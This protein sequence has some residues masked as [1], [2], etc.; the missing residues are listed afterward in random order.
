MK[1]NNKYS[2]SRLLLLIAGIIPSFLAF[3]F[4][5]KKNWIVFS[6]EFNKY[7]N[8]SSKYLFLYFLN[9]KSDS[10][11]LFFVINDRKRRNELI[12]EYGDYFIGTNTLSGILKVILSYTWITSSIETPIG[13]FFLRCRRIVIH[14][15][16]G[17]PVKSVGLSENYSS[18]KKFIYYN[19]V[20][21]NFTHFFSTSELFDE[22]WSKCIGIGKDRVIRA[23]LARNDVVVSELSC[24]HPV[25]KKKK[26]LYA[27]TWRPFSDT[28]LFPFSDFSPKALDIFLGKINATIYLRLHPNFES[29]NEAI[30]KQL[31]RVEM[32]RKSDQDDINEV[33]SQ[34]DLLVTDYSSIYVDYLLTEKPLLFLPYDIDD[35][36]DKVGLALDYDLYA[37]GPKP[38]NFYDFMSEVEMLLTDET[39]YKSDRARVN[40]LM[41]PIQS[42]FSKQNRE[43]IISLIHS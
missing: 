31:S 20:R 8:H 9:S 21:F 18:I 1:N 38:N 11:R 40:Y 27:P 26:I 28:K 12:A 13:G 30:C 4:P 17:A 42:D 2:F 19:I 7:F 32:I 39:Y 25:N 10:F 3:F 24:K 5:R 36:S 6:S 35:Y 23:G 34:F 15:S 41:N 43:V 14:L 29:E 16:H 22:N 33:L 37:P